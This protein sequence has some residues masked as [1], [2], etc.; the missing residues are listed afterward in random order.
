MKNV[1][2]FFLAFLIGVGAAGLW[3][4]CLVGC[5]ALLK[6]CRWAPLARFYGAFAC[7]PL[8]I[9]IFFTVGFVPVQTDVPAAFACAGLAI[10]TAALSAGIV[11]NIKERAPVSG[12]ALAFFC[13]DG[14]VM[15]VPQRLMM[16]SLLY[17]L[18]AH[19][20][21]Q[22]AAFYPSFARRLCGASRC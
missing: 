8:L 21:L 6:K 10:V 12:S 9:L 7:A 19:W 18:L 5:H 2:S 3:Y 17:G 22:N 14:I 20:Q 15:E 4:F 1:V 16:Q 13:M 11:C